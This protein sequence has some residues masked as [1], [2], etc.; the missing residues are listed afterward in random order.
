MPD[1]EDNP[2]FGAHLSSIDSSSDASSVEDDASSVEDDTPPAA[3]STASVL[4]TVNIKSHDPVFLSLLSLTMMNGVASLMHSS[5][6]LALNPTSPLHQLR[7]NA[8]IRSGVSV[9]NVS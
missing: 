9:I 5:A 2:L 3:P 4:Q 7:R 8:V 6:S 1:M